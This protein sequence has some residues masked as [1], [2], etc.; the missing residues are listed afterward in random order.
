AR[1]NLTDILGFGQH[2]AID[3]VLIAAVHE[4][5]CHIILIGEQGCDQARF[6]EVIHYASHRRHRRFHRIDK[7]PTLDSPTRQTLLDAAFGTLVVPLYQRGRLDPRFTEAILDP[8]ADLRLIIC[9]ESAGK[10]AASFPPDTLRRPYE[11]MIRPLR[12][13]SAEIP[14]LLDKWLIKR[15]S[16]L[17]FAQLRP[18][19]Q[20]AQLQ[21][22]WRGNLQELREW[23]DLLATLTMYAS[24]NELNKHS[25]SLD[26]RLKRLEKDK[27][28]IKV[29]FPLVPR[30]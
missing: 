16:P 6:G 9:A 8:Q 1:A 3:D 12:E 28:K 25:D 15:R 20:T 10:I 17:R 19:L 21:Y 4:P 22:K 14:Q 7:A 11:V 2:N 13:R 24:R 30:R 18:E 23:A 5:V 29:Q 26:S 27:L